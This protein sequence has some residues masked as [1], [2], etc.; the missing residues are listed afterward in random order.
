MVESLFFFRIV[1]TDGG[2]GHFNAIDNRFCQLD[3]CPN[4]GNTDAA[5]T[6]K[7]NLLCPDHM[8]KGSGTLAISR[9][10]NRRQVGDEDDPG[11]ER[12]TQDGNT[13]GNTDEVT[14]TE[15]S[16]GKAHRDLGNGFADMNPVADFRRSDV[17]AVG[18]K[19]ENTGQGGTKDDVF[20]ARFLFGRIFA[21]CFFFTNFA[22]DF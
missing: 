6:D 3:Q 2:D 22:A 12:T 5:G 1:G 18:A 16:H 9:G 13:A 8:R 17:Q 11:Q 20:H 14:G 7:A 4:G 15:K 10:N 21:F 19:A